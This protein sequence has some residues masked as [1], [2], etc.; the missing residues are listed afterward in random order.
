MIAETR[1]IRLPANAGLRTC[2]NEPQDCCCDI[3]GWAGPGWYC[4]ED[5]GGDCNTVVEL[6]EDDRCD[7]GIAICSG[8]Y[9]SE[10]D[11]EA[12]CTGDP[13]P[14]LTCQSHS[15][16]NATAT[17]SD[18]TGT[19][20]CIPAGLT[21]TAQGTDSCTFAVPGP[22]SCPGPVDANF[23]TLACVG[24]NYVVSAPHFTVSYLSFTASPFSLVVLLTDN[25][26]PLLTC[27]GTLKVTI[28]DP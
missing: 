13:P 17:V 26:I 12:E 23:V 22:H 1:E 28:T 6:T 24:G 8:P 14:D 19:C 7:T 18:Q 3:A 5:G 21:R 20:T 10:A 15:F 16:S 9:D 27:S 4:V 25:S 11:A 2:E